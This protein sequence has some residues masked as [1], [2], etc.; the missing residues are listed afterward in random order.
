MAQSVDELEAMLVPGAMRLTGDAASG[1]LIDIATQGHHASISLFGAQVLHWR[2]AGQRPVLWLSDGAQFDQA[3]AIRGGIPICWPWFAGH[4]EHPDWMAHGFARKTHWHLDA[5]LAVE[6]GVEL[7]LSLPI[8]DWHAPFWPQMS[9]PQ[10]K[11]M[12]SDTLT[13]ELRT[14]NA[15]PHDI[16][17]SEALH[18]YFAVSDIEAV[19][20]VGL[21]GS[22]F[23]DNL[24]VDQTLTSMAPEGGQI[25]INAEIDRIYWDIGECIELQ[26]SRLGRRIALNHRDA[27]NAVVW[28]PWIDKSTRMADMGPADAH[29]GMV[30][31]ETG[32]I[33]T[34]AIR[35]KPSE[36]HTLKTTVSVIESA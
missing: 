24:V 3:A 4:P 36:T 1:P 8:E 32:N 16:I 21:E 11:I 34:R 31:I 26:D 7:Q 19:G 12:V 27:A 20:I 30:C 22:P 6:A 2:P 28:N 23:E 29:R 5:A 9:R 15:D 18:S 10:I 17:F 33:G 35:L 14:T 25:A 13:I